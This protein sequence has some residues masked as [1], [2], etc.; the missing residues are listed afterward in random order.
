MTTLYRVTDSPIGPLTIAGVDGRIRHLRMQDQTHEPRDRADWIRDDTAFED[1]VVQLSEYFAGERTEFELKIELI[2]SAFQR[3]V[4]RALTTIPYGQT[5]TYGQIARQIGAP[6][7]SRAVGLANGHN[8]ISIIVPCHRVIGSNG[9]LTGYGGGLERKRI[10]LGLEQR[11][12]AP[13][14]FD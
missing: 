2:G 10:L 14:L 3:R 8:P 4:W 11:R 1:A 5:R 7:A 9:A 13:A 6:N 12:T